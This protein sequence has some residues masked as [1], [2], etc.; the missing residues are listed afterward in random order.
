MNNTEEFLLLILIGLFANA[1]DINLANN[2][3]ILLLFA[4]LLFGGGNNFNFNNNGSCCS[5]Y[6]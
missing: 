6:V 2:T 1:N 3:S 4:L 5:R